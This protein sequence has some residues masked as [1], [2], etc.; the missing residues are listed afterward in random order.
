MTV[1]LSLVFSVDWNLGCQ[2]SGRS[3]SPR[4]SL[5]IFLLFFGPS[6]LS[7]LHVGDII[8]HR[9]IAKNQ[10]QFKNTN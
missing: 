4:S 2:P 3:E 9:L 7:D 8:S 6:V 5:D 1:I 10:P